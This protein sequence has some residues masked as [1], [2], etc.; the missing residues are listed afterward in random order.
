MNEEEWILDETVTVP[1]HLAS[2]FHVKLK[3]TYDSY[4]IIHGYRT[5]YYNSQDAQYLSPTELQAIYCHAYCQQI[6]LNMHFFLLK[7][8]GREF[9]SNQ[10]IKTILCPTPA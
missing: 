7:N 8:M 6:N 9:F 3:K 5:V 4:K 2:A 1:F 10:V